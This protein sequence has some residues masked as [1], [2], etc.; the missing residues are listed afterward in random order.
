MIRRIFSIS[1]LLASLLFAGLPTFACAESTPNRDCCPHGPLA[2]CS[3]DGSVSAPADLVQQCCTAGTAGSVSF[4][5]DES[6]NEF[7]KHLKHSDIPAVAIS[8]EISPSAY[9]VSI[10]STSIATTASFS[11][12]F[13]LLYLSTGRLRL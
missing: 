13:A 10:K 11:P 2:P 12:S 7:H 6:S 1:I 5:T 4:A 9:F 8:S 3:V